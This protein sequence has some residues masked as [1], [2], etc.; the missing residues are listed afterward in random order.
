M[1]IA[2]FDS[3][4]RGLEESLAEAINLQYP[5]KIHVAIGYAEAIDLAELVSKRPQGAFVL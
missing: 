4:F 1:N 5:K 2:S 3:L